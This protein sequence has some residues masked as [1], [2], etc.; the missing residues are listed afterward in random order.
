VLDRL[1]KV[2]GVQSAGLISEI[3]LNGSD[4]SG[5]INMEGRTFPPG[6]SPNAQKRIVSPGYFETLRIPVRQGR[7]F[8]AADDVRSQPAIVVS[9]AFARQW[10]P[11]GDAVGKRIEF[12][13]DMDGLQTIIGVVADVKHNGLDDPASSAVYV[14]Y[15]QR[16]DSA[17]S[18]VVR[19]DGEPEGMIAGVREQVKA[20][21]SSRPMTDVKTLESIVSGSVAPRRLSLELVGGFAAIGLLLAITGIYS[22]VSYATAQRSREFGIRLALG[23]GSGL[24]MR[25][26]L[27]QGLTMALAGLAAGL[28]GAFALGGVVRSQLFGIQPADPLTLITVSAGLAAVALL[29]C[30]IPARRAVRINPATVLRSE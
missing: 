7:T 17:F 1:S 21:D 16:P 20:I 4:T 15:A 6:Q 27:R 11:N 18:V 10:F 14:T 25:L 3:P 12:N 26:V 22:V 2:H 28:I 30:Y 24:V 29:A 23:A 19:A 9:E 13:W 5:T 8:T